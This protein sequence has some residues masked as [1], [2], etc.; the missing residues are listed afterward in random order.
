MLSPSHGGR[1]AGPPG[2]LVGHYRRLPLS[3]PA[4]TGDLLLPH[5][6][7]AMNSRTWLVTRLHASSESG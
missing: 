2:L 7:H 5:A 6:L 3:G 4:F 1:W